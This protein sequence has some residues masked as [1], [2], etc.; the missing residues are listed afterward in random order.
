MVRLVKIFK[1]QKLYLVSGFIMEHIQ[2]F[3][4]DNKFRA[5]FNPE[6]GAYMRTG[7]LKIQGNRVIDTGVDPYMT[8]FPELID[9]GIMGKCKNAKRCTVGCYQGNKSEG[10]NMSVDDYRSIMKQCRGVF[11]VALGGAGSPDEHEDFEEILKITREHNIVPNYTTS[12]ISVDENI[13]RITK[14]YCGAVAVSWYKQDYTWEALKLFKEAG[15]TTNVH[16]VLSKSSIGEAIDI[17]K[18]N[19]YWLKDKKNVFDGIEALVFLFYKPVGNAKKEEMLDFDRDSKLI[20]E[21][22]LE[23]GKEHPFKVGFDSCSIPMLLQFRANIHNESIDTCEGARFS[24]YIHNDMKMTPC[25]FDQDF[26]YSVDLR[27]YS[28]KDAW[29]SEQFN[30]FRESHKKGCPTCKYNIDCMGSCPMLKL[31][32]EKR[33]VV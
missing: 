24:C 31:C 18:N 33:F 19:G 11:Q 12:G 10:K 15:C 25:S 6:T 26:K 29:N 22:V 20:Q 30:A 32:S 4:W 23:V 27:K 14:E 28:I 5:I 7:I 21:F 8:A 1:Y 16:F 2:K 9:I 3:D 17:L 13:A